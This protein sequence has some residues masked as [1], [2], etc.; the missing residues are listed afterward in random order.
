MPDKA[1]HIVLLD[2][3]VFQ[4]LR[5]ADNAL[6]RRFQLVGDV[7]GELAAGLLRRLALGDIE[8][9]QHRADRRAVCADAADIKLPYAP[10]ALGARFAMSLLHRSGDGKAHIM[11]AVNGQEIPAHAAPVRAEEHARRGIDAQH[12]PFLVQ[13]HESLAHIIRDLRKFIFLPLQLGKLRVDLPVLAVDAPEQRGELLI[14]VVIERMLE[15]QLIER[16]HDAARDALCQPSGKGERHDQHDKDRLHHAHEQHARG[17]AADGNAQDAAVGKAARTVHR[18]LQK[19]CRIA[20]ALARAGLKRLAHLC[21]AGV[22]FKALR[23]GHGVEAHRAVRRDPR[24]AAA[25][26]GYIGKV[27]RAV[28]LHRRGGQRKLVAQLILLHTAEVFIQ[29]AHDDHKAGKQHRPRHKQDGPK[30][31]FCHASASIR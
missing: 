21:T 4:Q 13:Q 7:C 22:V 6:K 8:R 9:Q 10:A 12:R 29:A 16:L 3:A 30:D 28:F 18:L 5:A 20:R 2:H 25:L 24:Q 15:V 14:S 11:A 26:G 1:R 27:V 23:V 19:R 17:R 31:L